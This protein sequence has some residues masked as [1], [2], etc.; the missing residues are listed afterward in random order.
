M[1]LRSYLEW[2]TQ[3]PDV[4]SVDPAIDTAVV[5]ALAHPLR[6]AMLRALRTQGP[7]TASALALALGESS[8]L[9]SYHLRVLAEHGLIVDDPALGSRRDR[10]WRA[11][12]RETRF[13]MSSV[14]DA[15]PEGA[16]ADYFRS[17]AAVYAQRLVEFARYRS[18]GRIDAAWDPVSDLSDWPLRLSPRQAAELRDRVH[19][20]MD[21]ARKAPPEQDA[22]PLDV[23][24]ALMPQPP[25]GA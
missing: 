17:V 11:A 4:L 21:A 19:A 12:H 16:G 15:D 1:P 23:Q 20:L 14:S 22:Q 25:P 13:T 9:T 2:V 10:Y 8:G 7:A 18:S 6:M 5:R 3:P 24:F